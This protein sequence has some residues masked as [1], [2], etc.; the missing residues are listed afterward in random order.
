MSGPENGGWDYGVAPKSSSRPRHCRWIEDADGVW[1]SSCGQSW[2]FD[3]GGPK[4]NKVRYCHWCG[5]RVKAKE[6]KEQP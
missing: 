4:E 2:V 6:Q 3:T 1:E 5:K